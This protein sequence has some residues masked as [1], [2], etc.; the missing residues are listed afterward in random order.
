MVSAPG[1]TI[2]GLGSIVS[3]QLSTPLLQMLTL[4]ARLSTPTAGMSFCAAILLVCVEVG[5]FLFVE[6]AAYLVKGMVFRV[7]C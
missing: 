5:V 1:L 4:P 2:P 3:A 6:G 7:C